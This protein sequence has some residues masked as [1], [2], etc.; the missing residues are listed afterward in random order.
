MYRHVHAYKSPD[1]SK[2]HMDMMKLIALT[3]FF[4]EL[5]I[6]VTSLED[7]LKNDD[8]GDWLLFN[9]D[10]TLEEMVAVVDATHYRQYYCQSGYHLQIFPNGTIGG[11][12]RDHDRYAILKYS[13]L[14]KPNTIILKGVDSG[15]YLAMNK[16][17]QLYAKSTIGKDCLFKEEPFGE[18]WLLRFSSARHPHH[19]QGAQKRTSDLLYGHRSSWYVAIDRNG[20]PSNAAMTKPEYRR[21]KFLPRAVDPQ[22][23]PYLYDFPIA[24][25]VELLH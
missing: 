14:M 23:V 1:C 12:A 7:G 3:S 2:T 25:D 20:Q 10:I 15:L 4:A 6:V 13:L 5:C 21:V 9:T 19:K 18:E 8:D 16:Y 11:T 17:G 22:K 24:R